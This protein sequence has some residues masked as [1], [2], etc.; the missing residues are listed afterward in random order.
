MSVLS[1]A[2]AVAQGEELL[3]LLEAGKFALAVS[4][5]DATM[6]EV[7]PKEALETAWT[8]VISE[9]GPFRGIVKSEPQGPE[10]G[11]LLVVF[12]CEFERGRLFSRLLF[13]PEGKLAGM[14]FHA[15]ES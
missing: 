4:R 3:H 9:A 10:E 14:C 1:V 5:F 13:D 2:Q 11:I 7:V 15:A 6:Q 8:Q 12:T